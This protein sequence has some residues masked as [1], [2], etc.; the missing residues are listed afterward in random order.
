MVW[1]SGWQ[2]VHLFQFITA[3]EACNAR[4][5]ID[6]LQGQLNAA[7]TALADA[8]AEEAEQTIRDVRTSK[9]NSLASLREN[10]RRL[11]LQL[12][13]AKD[14]VLISFSS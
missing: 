10:R 13:T 5:E 12:K 2:A 8:E 4:A 1:A 9:A 14:K 3:G 6:S 11:G 7:R